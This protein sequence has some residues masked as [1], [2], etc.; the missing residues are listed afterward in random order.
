MRKFD[1]VKRRYADNR[2][3]R[4]TFSSVFHLSLDMPTLHGVI[5]VADCP[6]TAAGCQDAQ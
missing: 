2:Q 5:R 4:T 6:S 1:N 3:L